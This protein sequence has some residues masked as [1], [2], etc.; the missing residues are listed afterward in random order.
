MGDELWVEIMAVG[1]V[2]GCGVTDLTALRS[3]KRRV[4]D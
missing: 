1:G 4:A 2:T 3:H